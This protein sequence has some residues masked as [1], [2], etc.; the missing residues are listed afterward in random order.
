I[1]TRR[2]GWGFWGPYPQEKLISP[3]PLPRERGIQGVRDRVLETASEKSRIPSSTSLPRSGERTIIL[4][5]Q[6][7]NP[8][9]SETVARILAK[10][11]K[12]N[13]RAP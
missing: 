3:S 4:S 8:I 1:P 9:Q 6:M 10:E 5:R 12:R 2:D 7:W 11:G 13:E